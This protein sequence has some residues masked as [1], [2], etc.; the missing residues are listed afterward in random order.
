MRIE[1]IKRD[2]DRR[3]NR[4]MQQVKETGDQIVKRSFDEYYGGGTPRVYK[5]NYQS[6][7][8]AYPGVISGGDLSYSMKI[9]FEPSQI[10]GYSSG[11][12]PSGAQVF[13]WMVNGAMGVV[14]WGGFAQSALDQI[15]ELVS[16]MFGSAFFS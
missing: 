10:P 12:H 5:R 9:G 2:V 16:Q 4:A 11:M 14:G 13:E 8:G 1:T 6:K 3:M 15:Q 7:S